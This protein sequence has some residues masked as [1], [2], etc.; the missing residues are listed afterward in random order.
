MKLLQQIDRYLEHIPFSR[1]TKW[2]IGIIALGMISIGFFML[3]S[4]FAI[5]YDYETLF[6]KRTFPQTNLENI[7]DS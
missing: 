2:F 7:K 6:T 5:K 3:V 1:K 4:I